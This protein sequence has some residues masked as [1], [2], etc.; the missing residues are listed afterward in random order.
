[1]ILDMDCPTAEA[2]ADYGLPFACE[3][4][5]C[6]WRWRLGRRASAGVFSSPRELCRRSC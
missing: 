1:V 4:L 5:G 6:L 3:K 2:V